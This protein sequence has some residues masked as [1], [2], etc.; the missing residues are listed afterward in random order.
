MMTA[1]TM[2]VIAAMMTMTLAQM[3]ATTSA[4]IGQKDLEADKAV[5]AGR[6]A[7]STLSMLVLSIAMTLT[8]PSSWT[9]HVSFTKARST[10]W[11]SARA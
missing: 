7:Q 8:M 5:V 3:I 1:A 11:V 4:T 6:I 9:V 10:P 2:I